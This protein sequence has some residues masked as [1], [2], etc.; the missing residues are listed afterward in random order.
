[1][2]TKIVLWGANEKDE[3]ILLAIELL[4][5]ENQ[6]GIYT[7][8]ENQ[9]T[10]EFYNKMMNIWRD[11][12]QVPLPEGYEYATRELKMTEGILPDNL[13]TDRTDIVNR[14]KTEWHFVVLSNKLSESLKDEVKEIKERIEALT[15]FDGGVWEEMKGFWTRVQGQV[16]EKNL[17]REHANELREST[18]ELFEKMKGLKKSM[19]VEF[20]NISETHL[21]TFIEKLDDV[22]ERITKGLGLQPIF[23]ELKNIQNQFRDTDFTR[24]DRNKVWKKLDNAFKK[25]KAKKYGDKQGDGNTSALS[26]I[27]RRYEGLL[28]AIGKMET[29]ISRDKK[30]VDFQNKRINNTDGQLE[31]QLRQAKLA[32]V[33]ERIKSKEVKLIE[34]LK[35]KTELESKSKAEKVREEKRKEKAE[36]KKEKIEVKAQIATEIKEKKEKLAPKSEKLE[37]AAKEIKETKETKKIKTP[38]PAFMTEEQKEVNEALSVPDTKKQNAS[39]EEE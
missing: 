21:K 31:A 5:L 32:M 30:E 36:I 28:A 33:D 20:Q 35:T 34:M 8:N 15:E 38:P 12:G 29:S 3:K 4:E 10:E 17:F 23:N 27:Q 18:N 22:E 11:G 16:R 9:A 14:A 2:K 6:I 37:K 1:M 7:F 13:K 24:R 19:D 26:R 39:S 25:V